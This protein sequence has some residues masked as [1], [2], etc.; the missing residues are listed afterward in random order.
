MVDDSFA[1]FD[2]TSRRT[3]SGRLLPQA[4]FESRLSDA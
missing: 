2:S 4:L 1:A 3:A